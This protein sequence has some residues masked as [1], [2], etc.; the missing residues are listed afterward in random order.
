MMAKRSSDS[1]LCFYITY[2]WLRVRAET[3]L[4]PL[5]YHGRMLF[6]STG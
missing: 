2:I 3:V 5:W 1:R 6:Y 4:T